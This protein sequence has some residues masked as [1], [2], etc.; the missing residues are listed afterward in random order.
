MPC[1]CCIPRNRSHLEV[2]IIIPN[3]FYYFVGNMISFESLEDSDVI[4]ERG[5]LCSDA[6]D[7]RDSAHGRMCPLIPKPIEQRLQSED[8]EKRGQ[9]AILPDRSLNRESL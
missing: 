3:D 6:A 7:Q 2:V 9:G 5:N 8:I 4:G 1:G